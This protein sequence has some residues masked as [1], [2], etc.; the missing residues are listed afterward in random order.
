V[1]KDAVLEKAKKAPGMVRMQLLTAKPLAMAVGTWREKADAEAF[2]QTG[3]FRDVLSR[4]EPLLASR[5]VPETWELTA[6]AQGDG[7]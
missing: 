3:V 1:W 2:M 5:P 4:L 7:A 6:F